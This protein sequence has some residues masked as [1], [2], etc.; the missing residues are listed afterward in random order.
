MSREDEQIEAN[1]EKG[2]YQYEGMV[3]FQCLLA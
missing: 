3:D 1:I 2:T